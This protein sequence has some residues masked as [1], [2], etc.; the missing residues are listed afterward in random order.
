MHEHFRAVE[1]RPAL[2]FGDSR[3]REAGRVDRQGHAA[4]VLDEI[5]PTIEGLY[6]VEGQAVLEGLERH[7]W[8]AER[9][10]VVLSREAALE[11]DSRARRRMVQD[12]PEDHDAV[13]VDD[14]PAGEDAEFRAGNV[15]E[16]VIQ[17]EVA[18]D[19]PRDVLP[20]AL[21]PLIFLLVVLG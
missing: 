8:G 10:E 3:A 12:H 20:R 2:G 14:L 9:Q 11:P 7:R 6:P 18:Y 13:A 16:H 21:F 19:L 4:S 17:R 5:V 15:E 1:D